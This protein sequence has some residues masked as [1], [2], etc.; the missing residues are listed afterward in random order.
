MGIDKGCYYHYTNGMPAV[1]AGLLGVDFRKGQRVYNGE[2][3]IGCGEYDSRADLAYSLTHSGSF[4]VSNETFQVSSE[5]DGK[6]TVP[7]GNEI[8]GTW[9]PPDEAAFLRYGFKASVTEG[10]VLRV[11][12]DDVQIA[13][14]TA[15]DGEKAIGY[16]MSGAHSLRFVCEGGGTATVSAFKSMLGRPWYV[17]A[18]RGDDAYDGTAALPA[19]DGSAAGPKKTLA[20]AMA[21]SGLASGDVV[22]VAEGTYDEGE[23]A[24]LTVGVGGITTNRVVVKAGVGL[25]ADAGPEK[26]FIV[27]RK[28][29]GGGTVG[30][31][32]MRCVYL[33]AG[34]WI[35]G[36]T[37]TNG[38]TCSN[39]SYGDYGG[40]VCSSAGGCTA[41]CRFVGNSARRGGATYG[42]WYVGCRFGEDNDALESSG[43][44]DCQG[45]FSSDFE[46][47]KPYGRW[48]LCNCTFRGVSPH[49]NGLQD[50]YNCFMMQESTKN[51]N[52]Y[53]CILT[54][55]HAGQDEPDADTRFNVT[56]ADIDEAT[57]RPTAGSSLVDA[58][59]SS[60]YE[61]NFPADWAIFKGMDV[62]GGQRIYNDGRIDVGAGEFDW[63]DTFAKTVHSSRASVTEATEG[64]KADA[65]AV[66]LG[67]GDRMV[68]EW[69]AA[70]ETAQLSAILSGTGTV[71]AFLDG[72]AL[73]LD[74]SGTTK[75]STAEGR[76]RLEISFVGDGVFNVSK[77][78]G[79]AGVVLF[80]R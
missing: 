2:I 47:C 11:Y 6:V 17:D 10:A 71:T 7:G 21:I 19:G 31:D 59:V 51:C 64:V 33:N 27:G 70:G 55:R 56:D 36:F 18:E 41:N 52:F 38:A 5:M 58:G 62:S 69:N 13:C 46:N 76:H 23:M 60:Y 32:A 16:A 25:L 50:V 35:F 37:V 34:S 48:I 14:V 57:L 75:F 63:R 68:I 24:P 65:G 79:M 77:L 45:V 42:G 29:S 9:T 49:G 15:E 44:Y 28:P 61:D 20:G 67:D 4:A 40:G 43:I 39:G 80:V 8:S 12:R 26:T 66:A 73:E 22:H 74:V 3:D 30:S 72:K 53:N 78:K 1:V 54:G